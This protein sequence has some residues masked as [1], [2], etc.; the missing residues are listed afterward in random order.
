MDTSGEITFNCFC[1]FCFSLT[2]FY[3]VLACAFHFSLCLTLHNTN[4][5]KGF[6][7]KSVTHLLPGNS[8]KHVRTYIV[9][10]ARH[11]LQQILPLVY[12]VYM[13][14]TCT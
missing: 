11:T 12:A 2:H 8:F 3:S 6:T 9:H 5:L 4:K 13:G 1:L 10:V 7:F 14:A